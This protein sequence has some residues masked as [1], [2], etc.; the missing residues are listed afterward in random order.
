MISVV[1]FGS[2]LSE[3]SA[4]ETVPALDN[5]R[6][7]RVP[8]YRRVFDKVGVVFISRHGESPD[9]L[10]LAS[11]STEADPSCEIIAA[12]FE[13]SEADFLQLYEREHRYRWVEVETWHCQTGETTLGRMCTGYSDLDYRLNKCVTEEE[14]HRRVGQYYQGVLWR[15]DILP[16]P[17][18]LGFCLQA[19]ASQGAA[20][21]DNFL[22]SSFTADG[23]ALRD[24]LR[25]RPEL[26][27][28][29]PVNYSYR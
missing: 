9:S 8:G 11:C 26:M 2:L 6:L 3:E 15:Q 5:Y 29:A 21:L 1:G 23:R 22:D 13:C 20:V 7:V 18:Y 28:A 16:N 17:R 25:Q 24:Y 12:Q 10:E 19:A 4:R 14:Y 27:P